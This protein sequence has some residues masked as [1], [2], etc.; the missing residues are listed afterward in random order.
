MLNRLT[1]DGSVDRQLGRGSEAGGERSSPAPDL[2]RGATG[3]IT[4][5]DQRTPGWDGVQ[6]SLSD[7][8]RRLSELERHLTGA[9]T[10]APP[11]DPATYASAA[12]PVN[13]AAAT[14]VAPTDAPTVVE[15]RFI[16]EPAVAST[17]TSAPAVARDPAGDVRGA[18]RHTMAEGLAQVDALKAQIDELLRVRELLKM[19]LAAAVEQCQMVLLSLD[20]GA[21]P[22]TTGAEPAVEPDA[23]PIDVTPDVFAGT[24]LLSAGPFVEVS[25]V[26]ALE[27][28]LLG[29]AVVEKFELREFAGSHALIDV[30]LGGPARFV[31]EL[32]AAL[33]F[34]FEVA[35][36]TPETLTIVA[37]MPEATAP[38]TPPPAPERLVQR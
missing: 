8:N 28:A 19:S 27:Q 1:T 24:V 30:T 17:A 6:T 9:R 34:A 16:R 25:Q 36:A 20:G 29:L 38:P 10:G 31:D 35:A 12:E 3:G 21:D 33:P 11:V 32:R 13:G 22:A 15:P 14:L 37:A 26:T 7:V 4:I 23:A 18:A 2:I 5:D